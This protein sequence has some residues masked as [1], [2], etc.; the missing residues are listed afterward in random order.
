MTE[1]NIDRNM[2][3][4]FY[5]S[6]LT[7][8]KDLTPTE[9]IIYSFLVSKSIPQIEDLFDKDGSTIDTYYLYDY[10]EEHNWIDLFAISIRKL[11]KELNISNQSVINSI[12]KLR[13][14][15]YIKD[16]K[17]YIDKDLISNGYFEL[18]RLDVVS[19]QVLIFYSYLKD[20]SLRYGGKIDTYKVK[21]AEIFGLKIY[22]IKQYLTKLY[23]V[24][25]IKRLDDGKL[26]IM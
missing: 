8:R 2:K 22:S 10:V 25:L 16:D 12:S 1:L 9:R 19:G 7:G 18:Q 24:N 26:L 6:L 3:V 23:S 15:E 4:I 13:L 14:L 21:L 11:A 20:K 5:K 17:I